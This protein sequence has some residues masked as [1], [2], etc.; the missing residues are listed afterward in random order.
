MEKVEEGFLNNLNWVEACS[1]ARLDLAGAW[2]DTP[3]I[4]YECSGGS[5]VTNVAILVN[6]KK[7]IGAR[8]SIFNK[9]SNDALIRIIMQNSSD[10]HDTADM[11]RFEFTNLNEFRDYNKPQSVACL[12]KAV[13]V[14]T[15]LVELENHQSLCEQLK[16]KINGS[17]ELRTW[18]GLPHG[19]GLGTSSIL[20]GCVL[21]VIWYFLG[22]TVSNET[23]SYSIL[24][25]EQLMTTSNSKMLQILIILSFKTLNIFK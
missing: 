16:K 14:F 22:V 6:E 17:L 9:N 19:S 12:M 5:C 11:L 7:P 10:D 4:T 21:K 23:L 15:K 8:A 20:I 2:S 13:C 24:I 25:V 3:P 1:P 18:T